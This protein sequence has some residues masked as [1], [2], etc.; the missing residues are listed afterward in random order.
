MVM[1]TQVTSR[2]ERTRVAISKPATDLGSAEKRKE[3]GRLKRSLVQAIKV[4]QLS[5]HDIV[6]PLN[7]IH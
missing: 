6:F 1:R 5:Y 3:R 4:F 2:G 7:A